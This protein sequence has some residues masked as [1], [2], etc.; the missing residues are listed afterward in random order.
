MNPIEIFYCWQSIVAVVVIYSVTQL[1]KVA[2]TRAAGR[3][4]DTP[5]RRLAWKRYV[6]PAVPPVIGFL[7]GASIPL[8]P[9]VLDAYVAA[10]VYA[11]WTA[12]LCY[13]A[14]GL[15]MG[16]VADYLYSKITD[17]IRQKRVEVPD[18]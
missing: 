12:A 10:R 17:A 4:L 8:R 13:G 16:P 9:D 15:A 2:I 18:A 6:M 11:G 3:W 1:V 5:A 14:W 7:Y